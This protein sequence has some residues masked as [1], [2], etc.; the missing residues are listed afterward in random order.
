[1]GLVTFFSL[2]YSKRAGEEQNVEAGG[3]CWCPPGQT[4]G[5]EPVATESS[6]VPHVM[7]L[8]LHAKVVP[9]SRHS[10]PKSSHRAQQTA[11]ATAIFPK[12][13]KAELEGAWQEQMNLLV[14]SELLVT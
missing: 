8:C 7:P 5:R 1:M 9:A 2:E 11:A 6:Q 10:Q 14:I 12:D 13:S 3:T 4:E